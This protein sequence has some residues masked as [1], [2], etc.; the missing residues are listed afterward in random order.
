MKSTLGITAA[1]LFSVAGNMAS[2][3]SQDEC[4]IWL[5]L[6]SGFPSG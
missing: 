4:A 6:P 5:C 2:A 3:A 1:I